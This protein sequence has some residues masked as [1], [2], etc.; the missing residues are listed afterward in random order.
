V[1][2]WYQE[3]T[4][5]PIRDEGLGDGL[6]KYRAVGSIT[7][8]TTSDRPRYYL[9][10]NFA[11]LFLL[12]EIDFDVAAEAWRTVHFSADALRRIR[13]LKAGAL[14]RVG[15]VLVNFP[16]GAGSFQMGSGDSSVLTKAFVEVFAPQFL[17]NPVVLFIS[18]SGNKLDGYLNAR[19]QAL[20]L[21]LDTATLLPDV[22]LLDEGSNPM[23][24][25]FA[26]IV[27]SDGPIR[28]ERMVE[29]L[30]LAA[31]GG[32][33]EEA[34]SFITVFSNRNSSPFKKAANHLAWGSFAWFMNEPD[35]LV[36]MSKANQKLG[37]H[38]VK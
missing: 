3:N 12:P 24:L 20:G 38:K 15:A 29:F 30:R 25:V 11:E 14:A 10:S 22:I 26:E 35:K 6:E 27:H 2:R 21:Q 8:P 18:E 7:V 28:Q 32:F 34:C 19:L 9:E 1:D 5:E 33:D 37:L 36:V 31:G 16:N 23:R 13:L 17:V 4:R